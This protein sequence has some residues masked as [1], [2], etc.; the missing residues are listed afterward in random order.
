LSER[1]VAIVT[2]ASRGIGCETAKC[3]AS[4]G[5]HVVLVARNADTLKPIVDDIRAGGGMADFH[6]CDVGDGEALTGVIEQVANTMGRLD[7]LVNNAGMTRDMLLLRMTDADF[8]DVIRVNL[9]SVFVACRA[10]ARP[11]LR[12]RFGRIV[13]VG[14]VTGVWG[15][16]GQS[17]YAA[18]KSALHGFTASLAKEL[19]P[20][21]ITANVIAPGFIDTEMT[22]SIGEDM[23]KEAQKII[24]LRRFGQPL[25]VAH[26]IR[27]VCSDEA[28][29]Y[30]GQ[31]MIVDGGLVC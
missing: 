2:G 5:R 18:A 29:Y 16:S 9:R 24:P 6:T 31:V 20:K 12:G 26:A 27:W 23:R 17:N 11:M 14:S 10:A 4:A 13:N 15:N 3:L 22:K 7:I 21:G 30:S 19:G 8:D 1:R 25:E 28:S